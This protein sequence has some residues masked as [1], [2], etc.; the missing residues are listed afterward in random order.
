MNHSRQHQKL[1]SR[2]RLCESAGWGGLRAI[3]GIFVLQIAMNVSFADHLSS[4]PM[5]PSSS[6][7]LSNTI[8]ATYNTTHSWTKVKHT[9]PFTH[10]LSIPFVDPQFQDRIVRLQSEILEIFPPQERIKFQAQSPNT[11]HITLCVLQLY[12]EHKK[13]EAIALFKK[14]EKE[15]D[16]F[17]QQKKVNISFGGV[18]IFD[19]GVIYLEVKDIEDRIKKLGN[20]WID[21]YVKEG[22][23]TESQFPS[24]HL[25][26]NKNLVYAKTYHLTLFRV[27]QGVDLEPVMKKFR[28]FTFGEA[29]ANSV[30]L[31]KMGSS[32]EGYHSEIKYL[33]PQ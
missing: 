30:N 19:S 22:L 1:F 13:R 33:L 3:I 25:V 29:H 12:P 28:N 6:N 18:G 23:I 17:L 14:Q 20:I 2:D 7:M 32:Q 26:R 8:P 31:S 11:L 21:P 16:A 9:S 24:M 5:L 27:Q 15:V 4:G 10:F